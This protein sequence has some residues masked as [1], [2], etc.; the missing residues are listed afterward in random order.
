VYWPNPISHSVLA[1]ASGDLIAKD[2]EWLAGEERGPER[3][4]EISSR[5]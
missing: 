3:E 2:D 1:C 4:D 5:Q